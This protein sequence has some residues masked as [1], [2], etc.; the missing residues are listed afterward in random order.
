MS[1]LEAGIEDVVASLGGAASTSLVAAGYDRYFCCTDFVEGDLVVGAPQRAVGAAVQTYKLHAAVVEGSEWSKLPR[2]DFT[3]GELVTLRRW[4]MR[5]VG[6]VGFARPQCAE[7]V[8]RR[9]LERSR[10]R[11]HILADVRCDRTFVKE[12]RG[13]LYVKAMHT[14]LVE[15]VTACPCWG[16]TRCA[17]WW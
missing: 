11:F 7:E 14:W 13:V 2:A 5:K 1:E 17:T 3:W 4:D 6:M 15:G 8:R 12:A 16:A 10:C 9:Y